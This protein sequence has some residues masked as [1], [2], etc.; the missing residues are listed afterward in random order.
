MGKMFL[1]LVGAHSKWLEVHL[2]SSATSLLAIEKMRSILVIH[3][4]PDI[5]VTDNGSAFTSTEFEKFVKQNEVRHVKSGT[6]VRLEL[7]A[8]YFQFHITLE[9]SFPGF[10]YMC[11]QEAWK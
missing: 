4:P 1:V 10:M 11:I 8:L 9:L 7:D 2:V 6:Y 3:S 5:L